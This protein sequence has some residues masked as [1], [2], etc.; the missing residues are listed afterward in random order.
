MK[1]YQYPAAPN[2]LRVQILMQEK[3]IAAELVNVTVEE[4]PAYLAVNPLGQFP[5]LELDDGTVIT[6]SLTICQYLDAISGPPALFGEGLEERTRIGMWERRAEMALFNPS[7]EY[8]HHVHPMFAGRIVQYP[9]WAQ[10]LVPRAERMV[11]VMAAQLATSPYLAGDA[12]SAADITAFL[13]Y[14]GFVFYKGLAPAED[15]AFQAWVARVGQRESMAV[16]HQL[17][18]QFVATGAAI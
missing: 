10:T 4:R 11:E 5:A 2:A 12:F 7:L 18:A 3:G 1:L 15:P 9:E 6:E 17:A 16:L 13:G 14:F 8:G